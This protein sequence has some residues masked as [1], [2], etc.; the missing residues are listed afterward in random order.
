MHARR[1]RSWSGVCGSL[2]DPQE[3]VDL[4]FQCVRGEA[5]IHNPSGSDAEMLI[6]MMGQD[7]RQ[8]FL[9]QLEA[10]LIPASAVSR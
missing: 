6:G 7:K 1:C 9:D 3:V 10:M 4:I 5:S 8:A 2:A